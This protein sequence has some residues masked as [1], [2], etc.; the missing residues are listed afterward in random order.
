MGWGGGTNVDGQN[1][2][3][4]CII[5]MCCLKSLDRRKY[6]LFNRLVRSCIYSGTRSDN[7]VRQ[8]IL[9]CDSLILYN[10]DKDKFNAHGRIWFCVYVTG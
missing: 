7:I 6:L 5:E 1:Q 9:L 10:S 3:V 8:C 4:C 2:F